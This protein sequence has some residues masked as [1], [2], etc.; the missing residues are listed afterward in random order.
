MNVIKREGRSLG[1]ILLGK[2]GTRRRGAG[3][4]SGNRNNTGGAKKL[5]TRF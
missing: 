2:S 5:H 3:I 4:S 1:N